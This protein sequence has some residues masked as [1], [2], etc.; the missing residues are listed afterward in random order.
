M[1]FAR[2]ASHHSGAAA[3]YENHRVPPGCLQGTGSPLPY[4]SSA[5]CWSKMWENVQI[6][7]IDT[8]KNA[9]TNYCSTLCRTGDYPSFVIMFL[10]EES[11]RKNAARVANS[12]SALTGRRTPW[13]AIKRA[14]QCWILSAAVTLKKCS[15]YVHACADE[16]ALLGKQCHQTKTKRNEFALKLCSHTLTYRQRREL[17][18]TLGARRSSG[19]L[20][21]KRGRKNWTKIYINLK[22]VTYLDNNGTDQSVEAMSLQVFHILSYYRVTYS[23]FIL[24]LNHAQLLAFTLCSYFAHLRHTSVTTITR[25]IC[26]LSEI[27]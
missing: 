18:E 25:E 8:Q 1:F 21:A 20:W 23:F 14:V 11:Q 16:C 24:S 2:A 19:S 10:L 5:A 22:L 7:C 3:D 26:A 12:L 13:Q 17:C 6:R 4:W 27:H 9:Y 15:M